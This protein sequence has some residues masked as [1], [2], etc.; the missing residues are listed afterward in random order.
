LLVEQVLLE[1]KKLKLL[2][3]HSKDNFDAQS[4]FTRRNDDDM[5]IRPV[6]AA[7]DDGNNDNDDD[8]TRTL[9][10]NTRDRIAFNSAEVSQEAALEFESILQQSWVYRRNERN[11]CDASFVSSV[12]RSH[13]CSIFT[14]YSLADISI[15][16]VIAMPLTLRELLNS[17][18][19][20]EQ[21]EA[22]VLSRAT[23]SETTKSSSA[24]K[25][26]EETVWQ[27]SGY[28]STNGRNVV[29][30]DRNENTDTNADETNEYDDDKMDQVSSS[31]S[32]EGIFFIPIAAT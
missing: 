8:D 18:H 16:S 20:A 17:Q 26:P 14:G 30:H 32:I 11:E 31:P 13:A 25:E 12:Q 10:N 29:E 24:V 5:T 21:Y 23:A 6:D 3:F 4:T 2:L 27:V 1:N 19:Y 28:D 15:L 9:Y 22:E 7:G